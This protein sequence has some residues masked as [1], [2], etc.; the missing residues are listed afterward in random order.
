LEASQGITVIAFMENV[1]IRRRAGVRCVM[2]ETMTQR[3]SGDLQSDLAKLLAKSRQLRDR[4]ETLEEEIQRLTRLI[5]GTAEPAD[6]VEAR[7]DDRGISSRVDATD[8]RSFQAAP[9]STASAP[10]PVDRFRQS[11]DVPSAGN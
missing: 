1:D 4:S 3:D 8:D 11:G 9:E 6:A 5:A 2:F 7:E 10:L